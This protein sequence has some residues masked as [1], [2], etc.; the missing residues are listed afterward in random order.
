MSIHVQ[1]FMSW[2]LLYKYL[3]VGWL[4]YMAKPFDFFKNCQLF[5]K[6]DVLFYPLTSS[7]WE[8]HLLHISQSLGKIIFKNLVI[9]FEVYFVSYC[10]YNL[11]FPDDWWCWASFHKLYSYIIFLD[12]STHIFCP[13]LN[14]GLLSQYRVMSSLDILNLSPMSYVRV[15]KYFSQC[16]AFS[17]H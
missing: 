17:F 2:I 6:V 10:S 8:F 7:V 12:V 14:L 11:Q 5:S 13:L 15:T 16:F 4:G 3:T 1:V 9:L